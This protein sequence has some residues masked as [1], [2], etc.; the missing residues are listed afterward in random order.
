MQL[1]TPAL[2]ITKLRADDPADVEAAFAIERDALAHDVPDFPPPC[3]YRH[4]KRLR[5]DFPGRKAL[6]ALGRLDGQPVGLLEVELTTYDNLDNAGVMLVVLPEHRRRGVGRALFAHAGDLVRAAG[7]K[8]L[9]GM[10]SGSLPGGEPRDEAGGA[11]ARAMGMHAALGDVRRRLEIAAIDHAEHERLLAEGWAKADG[12]SIVQW[13][14]EAPEEYIDDIAALDSSFVSEAPLGDLEWEPE[15]VDADRVRKITAA[16]RFYG[17]RAYN[18]GLRHD[19]TDRLVAWS[20]LDRHKTT[21]WHAGQG[22]TLVD[23]R[24]RGHRL[25]II[26]KIENLRLMLRNE[27][28]VRVID[29]WNASVNDHMIAINEAMGFRAV[30][31][32]MSWQMNL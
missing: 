27:P 17:V 13:R 18:T 1:D 20:A 28:E 2:T 23:P 31:A 7:R 24:H 6:R 26:A 15:K 32:F 5:H 8:R 29:T 14:D 25:G 22:I 4:G 30:D 12:Y 16:R 3:R 10:T 11:F 9:F 19:A 21:P